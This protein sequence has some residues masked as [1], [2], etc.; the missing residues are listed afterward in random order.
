MHRKPEKFMTHS[1]TIFSL[2]QWSGT[3]LK[4]VQICLLIYAELYTPTSVSYC[5][6]II[7]LGMPNK[8]FKL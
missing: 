4:Y 1:V 8:Y 6:F 5:L 7:P 3:K 2:L